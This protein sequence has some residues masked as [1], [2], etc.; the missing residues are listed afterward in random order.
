MNT[1]IPFPS[2]SAIEDFIYKKILTEQCCP[3]SEDAV[4]YI[5]KQPRL[6]AYGIADLIKI[7]FE[8]NPFE[9]SLELVVVELKNEPLKPR[10]LAQLTRYMSGVNH[11]MASYC[12][13]LNIDLTI[14]G[15]LVGIGYDGDFVYMLEHISD[16]IDCY[17][18]N[19]TIENGLEVKKLGDG[20][21]RTD[22]NK[23]DISKMV[24]E[25]YNFFKGEL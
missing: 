4:A 15:E 7:D 6:G 21:Y 25:V 20:W 3:I 9:K 14:R 18:L 13:R 17:T 23:K 5:L 2:E 1:T 22:S 24:R 11:M 19:I 12:S 16:Y 10:D 8:H